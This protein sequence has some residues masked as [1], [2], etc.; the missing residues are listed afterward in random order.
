M[1]IKV[2]SQVGQTNQDNYNLNEVKRT[3]ENIIFNEGYKE[4]KAKGEYSKTELDKSL[5]KLNDFLR[6][7]NTYA[8]YQIHE[9][10]GD[11]MVKIINKDTK[12]VIMECPPQK[13]ID[14]VA[15]MVELVGTAIDN[16]A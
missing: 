9:I 4:V 11:I 16:K 8:E 14:M 10:F 2:R 13:I 3:K 5:N 7:E 6:S 15:K 1:D 12:E